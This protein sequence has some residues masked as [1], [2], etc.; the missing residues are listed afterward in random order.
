[1]LGLVGTV[2]GIGAA[3]PLA[4]L[5]SRPHTS[6]YKTG[7]AAGERVVTEGGRPLRPGDVVAGGVLT[8]FPESQVSDLTAPGGGPVRHPAHQHR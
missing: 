2:F 3:F 4:S 8:V 5:G 7:W 6:L 1:M